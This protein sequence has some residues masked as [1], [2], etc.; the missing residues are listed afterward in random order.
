[1]VNLLWADFD[2]KN[3]R[4]KTGLASAYSE[5]ANMRLLPHII[6]D[7]GN[8]Y[9]AYW[10]LDGLYP[11]E[12]VQPVMK[13]IEKVHRTD[14]CSDKPRILRIPGTLNYKEQVAKPVRLVRFEVGLRP[15]SLDAFNEY[16]HRDQPKRYAKTFENTGEWQPSDAD[17]PKFGQG[18]RNG[19]LTRIAGAMVHRGLPPDQVVTNLLMENELRCDPPLSATEVEAIARSV[20]RYRD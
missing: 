15:Y 1:M 17:A 12:S 2:A 4:G 10:R 5:I 20:E 18:V 8:G 6:V 13:G 11:F 3:F 16:L 19:A 9:H 14:H 7:S